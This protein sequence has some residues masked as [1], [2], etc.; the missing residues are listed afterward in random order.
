MV[1]G[2]LAGSEVASVAGSKTRR[3]KAAGDRASKGK[4]GKLGTLDKLGKH[5][6]LQGYQDKRGCT[7]GMGWG[8]LLCVWPW[9]LCLEW[10]GEELLARA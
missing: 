10:W 8:Q 3:R 6:T 7:D 2:S 9:W 4:L 1:I 5:P